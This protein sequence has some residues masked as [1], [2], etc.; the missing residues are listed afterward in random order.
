MPLLDAPVTLL[1]S[2]STAL[3]IYLTILAGIALF[4]TLVIWRKVVSFRVT[5]IA[6]LLWSSLW[7]VQ[8]Q[9]SMNMGNLWTAYSVAIATGLFLLYNKYPPTARRRA[10]L[11]GLA[12]ASFAAAM[13]HGATDG[14]FMLIGLL[15]SLPLVQKSVRI[16]LFAAAFAGV[17]AGV[18][19]WVI[20]AYLY[21]N[22]PF[23]RLARGG[24]VTGHGFFLPQLLATLSA[25]HNSIPLVLWWAAL[26]VLLGAGVYYTVRDRNH[27]LAVAGIVGLAILVQ[28][29]FIIKHSDPRYVLPIFA[30]WVF[31]AAFGLD[32]LLNYLRLPRI[33]VVGAIAAIVLLGMAAQYNV[34]SS[35][36][37]SDYNA[38]H[39]AVRLGQIITRQLSTP[40]RVLGKNGANGAA[41]GYY[42]GCEGSGFGAHTNYDLLAQRA[43]IAVLILR[44]QPIPA[45]ITHWRRSA[46]QEGHRTVLIYMQSKS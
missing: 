16:K 2:S 35:V 37:K 33:A 43:S 38:A 5:V 44:G 3:R 26:L 29:A 45:Q 9:T 8:N 14:V 11:V 15:V 34:L 36:S 20:E 19:E 12:V 7:I 22:G 25:D 30:L 31:V 17:A 6:G 1:T 41:V 21:F 39:S 40:C 24:H 27:E 32:R 23:H 46:V 42:A 13:M 4:V 10:T 28:Y 18:L